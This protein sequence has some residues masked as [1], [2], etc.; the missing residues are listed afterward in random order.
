VKRLPILGRNATPDLR[1]D[2]AMTPF[3]VFTRPNRFD[4]TL[5]RPEFH[6][7]GSGAVLLGVGLLIATRRRT[8]P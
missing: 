1:G 6:P 4:I 8:R 2:Q 3:S 5:T 7:A